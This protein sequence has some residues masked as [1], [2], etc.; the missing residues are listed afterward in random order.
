MQK[1]L[2][3][4]PGCIE[5]ALEIIGDKW[6]GLILREL[7]EDGKRF[8]QLQSAFPSMSPRTLSQRLDKLESTFVVEKINSTE[9]PHCS[10][11]TLTQKGKDFAG[12]LHQMA[13]W[14]EKYY[15]S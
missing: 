10:I 2:E 7:Y 14:G 8:N 3:K 15:N 9:A 6:T 12:I 1:H 5:A 4:K 13:K 11:Y